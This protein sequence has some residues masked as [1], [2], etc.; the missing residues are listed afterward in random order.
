MEIEALDDSQAGECFAG[1]VGEH[2]AIAVLFGKAVLCELDIFLLV[3]EKGGYGGR[4]VLNVPLDD[5]FVVAV[6]F[7]LGG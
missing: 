1:A 2:D 6:G 4:D 7:L 3:G 5:A